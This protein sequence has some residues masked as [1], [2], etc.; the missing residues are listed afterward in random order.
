M[1]TSNTVFE[2]S[3]QCGEF[4][5][6]KW[7]SPF[8]MAFNKELSRDVDWKGS[9]DVGIKGRL[10]FIGVMFWVCDFVYL[11]EVISLI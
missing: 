6:Q 7:K 8:D 2:Q 4:D 10:L 1:D 3:A 5:S 11:P 9:Q